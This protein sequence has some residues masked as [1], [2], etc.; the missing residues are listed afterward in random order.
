SYSPENK[1]YGLNAYNHGG[2]GVVAQEAPNNWRLKEKADVRDAS[3]YHSYGNSEGGI[4]VAEVT[5]DA[6][7]RISERKLEQN[8]FHQAKQN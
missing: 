5:R 1:R 4:V 7:G 2:L 8:K 6:N 3:P